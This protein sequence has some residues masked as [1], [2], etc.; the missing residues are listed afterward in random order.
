MHILITLAAKAGTLLGAF[1]FYWVVH[2]EL[3]STY[4][5]G[6]CLSK[7]IRMLLMFVALIITV[8]CYHYGWQ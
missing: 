7:L 6:G 1:L 5:K 2:S 4:V 3:T 8:T